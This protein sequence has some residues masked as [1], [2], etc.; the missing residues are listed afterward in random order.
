MLVSRR[1]D[2]SRAQRWSVAASAY[3]FAGFIALCGAALVAVLVVV[4]P[5]VSAFDG[6]GD[7][8]CSAIRLNRG[9]AATIAKTKVRPLP[10][11]GTAWTSAAEEGPR[12]SRIVARAAELDESSIDSPAH[13]SPE[14]RRGPPNALLA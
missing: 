3:T 12:L 14:T 13:R 7:P 9:C 8:A 6:G 4:P 2:R 10:R 11:A 5:L 1:S